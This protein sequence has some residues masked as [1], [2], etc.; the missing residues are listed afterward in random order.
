MQALIMRERELG[1]ITPRKQAYLFQQIGARGW[2]TREPYSDLFRLSAH[3]RLQIVG[4][5]SVFPSIT[6]SWRRNWDS[7]KRRCGNCWAGTDQVKMMTA[8]LG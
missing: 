4:V 5:G 3:G 2:R 6:E 7:L 1:I 8:Q